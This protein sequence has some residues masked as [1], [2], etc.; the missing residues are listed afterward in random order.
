MKTPIFH[1]IMWLIFHPLQ[2]TLFQTKTSYAKQPTHDGHTTIITATE[3]SKKMNAMWQMN[4]HRMQHTVETLP[5]NHRS[6]AR[7]I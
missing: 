4:D 6:T 7:Q 3:L 1:E 2:Y 5:H